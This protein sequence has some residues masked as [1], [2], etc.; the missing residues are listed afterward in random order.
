MPLS[1]TLKQTLPSFPQRP[2]KRHP[3]YTFPSPAIFPRVDMNFF[4]CNQ[5]FMGLK[6]PSKFA[7]QTVILSPFD[8]R[9]SQVKEDTLAG[10]FYLTYKGAASKFSGA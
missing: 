7:E 9:P 3:S 6:F 5:H 10:R 4:S 2:L 8:G 1:V